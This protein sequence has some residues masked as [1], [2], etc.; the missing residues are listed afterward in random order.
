MLVAT[1][2]PTARLRDGVSTREGKLYLLPTRRFLL[3]IVRMIQY[4]TD[5][6]FGSGEIRNLPELLRQL[7][8]DEGRLH[9]QIIK[10][11]EKIIEHLADNLTGFRIGGFIGKG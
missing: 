4:L 8:I 2:K 1:T 7:G 5:I 9:I 3:P 11:A 6:H 10:G